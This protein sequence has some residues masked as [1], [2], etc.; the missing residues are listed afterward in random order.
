MI[1]HVNF[2]LSDRSRFREQAE[3]LTFIEMLSQISFK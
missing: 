3:T 1:H 2:F